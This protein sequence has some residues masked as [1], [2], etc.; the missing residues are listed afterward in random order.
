MRYYKKLVF[1]QAAVSHKIYI[2][3]YMSLYLTLVKAYILMAHQNHRAVE[4][5][6]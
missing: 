6:C 3:P 5:L 2:L 1:F 4:E